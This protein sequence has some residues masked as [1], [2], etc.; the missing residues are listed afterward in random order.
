MNAAREPPLI[1][2]AS[3][4]DPERNA[5]WGR[6][7]AVDLAGRMQNNN[8]LLRATGWQAKSWASQ[9]PQSLI[10]KNLSDQRLSLLLFRLNAFKGV[11]PRESRRTSRRKSVALVEKLGRS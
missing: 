8:W 3:P 5:P 6:V 11:G 7:Y 2:R 10:Q 9:R 4:P 1:R